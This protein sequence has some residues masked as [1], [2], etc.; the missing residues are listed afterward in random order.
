MLEALSKPSVLPISECLASLRQQLRRISWRQQLGG[1][2]AAA[3]IGIYLTSPAL[4]SPLLPLGFCLLWAS[5][6]FLGVRRVPRV[7]LGL[8]A[9]IVASAWIAVPFSSVFDRPLAPTLL[10][11]LFTTVLAPLLFVKEIKPIFYWLIPGW[12]L[13]ALAMA[14]QWFAEGASR[15]GGIAENENAGSSFLL[16][17]AIFLVSDKRLRW[18]CIPLLLAIP[19]SGSRWVII[20]GASLFG[21]MF[22]SKYV[23]WRWALIGLALAFIAL[24][25]FQHSQLATAYRMERNHVEDVGY[26]AKVSEAEFSLVKLLT[27][28]GFHNTNLHS[29]PLRMADETG[30]ISAL[31]WAAVGAIALWRRPR[32][33]WQWWCLAAVCLLSVMYYFTWIGPLGMFWWLMVSPDSSSKGQ[34]IKR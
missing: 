4:I 21:L 31:A 18:L 22:I 30:L 32:Y 19:F 8:A 11:A 9:L 24:F 13:Q 20:V 17:G 26:R 27:P 33:S 12:F 7:V 1:A 5:V 25:G 29:L 14:W 15:A 16:L 2:S 34:H 23:P 3:A 10:L 6:A 28:R